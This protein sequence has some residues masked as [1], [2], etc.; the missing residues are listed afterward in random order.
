M[1]VRLRSVEEDDLPFL[2]RLTSDPDST[3]EF[4]WYGFQNPHRLRE[5][6][7]DNGMLSDDGG[8]LVIANGDV[9]VGFVSWSKQVANRASYYWSM[10]L[11]VA[12]EHRGQGH[13]TQ[14]HRL[15]VRY[16][17]DHSM[18]NRIEASTEISNL[19]EQR[20]L[21]KSGFT[22]EGVL[23]GCGFRA[24]QWRDGVLYSVIRSD[25][26]EKP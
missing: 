22:R 24:G 7:Q 13:G 20:A 25:L 15:L 9:R 4:Q 11:I 8:I 18:A 6:W 3:G 5:R 26:Q 1:T 2:H 12:P 17:F 21:E 14:A 23:R 16:L 10:G 19:A